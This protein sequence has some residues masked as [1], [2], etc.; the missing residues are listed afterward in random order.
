MCYCCSSVLHF[1]RDT[2]PFTC[3]CGDIPTNYGTVRITRGASSTRNWCK[4]PI[5][6]RI[7]IPPPPP[8]PQ[9]YRFDPVIDKFRMYLDQLKEM[10]TERRDDTIKNGRL[11]NILYVVRSIDYNETK[12]HL[13]A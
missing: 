8:P 7:T 9:S 13:S 6:P 10:D 1:D 11:Y 12:V 3:G 4:N 5:I 2:P